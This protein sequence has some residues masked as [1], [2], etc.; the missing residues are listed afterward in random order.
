[1]TKNRRVSNVA[2]L[3]LCVLF[4][5][6][7]LA[8]PEKTSSYTF[9]AFV[10]CIKKVVPSL[11]LF[12]V[13]TKIFTGI[14][15]TRIFYG[16]TGKMI[17]KALGISPAGVCAVIFGLVSGY[18][19]GA[20]ILCSL[21]K[22]GEIEK[23]EAASLLP[24]VTAA[25]PAF[26]LGTVGNTMFSSRNYGIILLVSQ[27][28]VSLLMIFLTR[29]KRNIK[30][31]PNIYESENTDKK[32]PFSVIVSSIKEAASA[33]LAVCSF[34]SFF[35]VIS[36]MII[37]FLPFA[38]ENIKISSVISGFFEISS[39]FSGLSKMGA[40]NIFS[41]IF[42]GVILGFSGLSVLFQTADVM[43]GTDV[44]IKNYFLWKILCG[45]LCG[46]FCTLLYMVF[47]KNSVNVFWNFFGKDT[48]FVYNLTEIIVFSLLFLAV[49]FLAFYIPSLVMRFF[50]KKR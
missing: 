15:G 40:E 38:A 24:F 7:S 48:A 11:F 30:D 6:L 49:I 32:P 43:N 13:L 28:A 8:F 19:M 31:I 34:I 5:V 33:L 39:G 41:Y 4:A 14:G 46:A 36:S 37:S 42:G 23:E 12:M 17:G 20:F 2:L 16:K 26:I 9:S 45:I 29:K 18:P 21:L 1:M 44:G 22:R 25:S 35:Y 3:F 50:S 10:L 27:T 47:F